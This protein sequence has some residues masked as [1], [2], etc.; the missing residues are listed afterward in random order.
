[1]SIFKSIWTHISSFFHDDIAPPMEAFLKQFSSDEGHL[2]LTTAL[3]VAPALVTGG[4]GAIA[5]EVL[6][7]VISQSAVL[8]AQD[9][10]KTLQQV[11]SALQIAKVAQNITT[12]GDTQIITAAT[13]AAAPTA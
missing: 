1:M 6:G 11:Q 13:P 7:T 12:P 8:A 4:F 9:I 10:T 5:Q 3:T 2:I